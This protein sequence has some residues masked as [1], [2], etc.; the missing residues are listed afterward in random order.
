M[1]C[2]TVLKGIASESNCD[3]S[4][5]YLWPDSEDT[6]EILNEFQLILILNHNLCMIMCI[7]IDP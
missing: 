4:T 1:L 6:K 3:S 7:D 2:E 5:M